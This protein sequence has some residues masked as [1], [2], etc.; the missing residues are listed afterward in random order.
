MSNFSAQPI[1]IDGKG[2]LLGRLASIISKQILSGQKVTVVR[3]EEINAS[4]SFF[5]NKLKYHNYLHKRHIV[6]PKKSGPFHFRAPSR[7]L[8]KAVRGM[9]PH[10]TSRGAAAL[11]RLELYEGVPPSQDKVKK[12]VVPSALRVLRLKPGR[13]FCTLKRISAE[14]GWNYKDVVDRLEEKRKVKGQAYFERKQAALKLRAKADA[15]VAKDEKLTQFG[16]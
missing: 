13:K 9:V 6:N 1:V 12:M 5:R 10:K 7:I 3:C 8:Y 16:Y 2:H 11:K 15:S 14:V 4:G